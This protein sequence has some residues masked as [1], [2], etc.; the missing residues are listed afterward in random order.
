MSNGEAST[1]ARPTR[2][3]SYSHSRCS[4]TW[5]WYARTP[6]LA[7][8]RLLQPLPPRDAARRLITLC[9][10]RCP[11]TTERMEPTQRRCSNICASK[12]WPQSIRSG[13][14]GRRQWSATPTYAMHLRRCCRWAR[15]RAHATDTRNQRGQ[16]AS[17]DCSDNLLWYQM[18][19]AAF[20]AQHLGVARYALEH[21][22]GINPGHWLSL[23]ILLNVRVRP[24]TQQYSRGA[25]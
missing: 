20:K 14:D 18:G 24:R 6:A 10:C 17:L 23:Q 12:T 9:P 15:A 4:S 22:L 1:K 3:R 11:R 7:P 25:G 5:G 2:T 8:P 19:R 13:S 21:G 16:A